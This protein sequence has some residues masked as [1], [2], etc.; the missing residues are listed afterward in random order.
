MYKTDQNYPSSEFPIYGSGQEKA[1]REIG[2]R[3]FSVAA[4]SNR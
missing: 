4:S 2:K 1:T 3:Q